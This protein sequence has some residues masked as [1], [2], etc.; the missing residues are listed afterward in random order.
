MIG[1]S[2]GVDSSVAA[3]LLLEQ[4]FQV[5]GLFMKNWEEDDGSEYCTAKQDLEDASSVADKLGIRLHTCNFASEYW[6]KVFEYF[7]K[8][9]QLLRTP[10]PDILCNREIKFKAFM[11]YA[12]QLGAQKI[13]TGHY[14]RLLLAPTG[15]TQLLKGVDSNKD[16]AY[17]LHALNQKQLSQSLFP[18]GCY[19]K[20]QVRDLA[21][22]LGFINHAK[23]DSTGICFI[24][25]RRFREFLQRYLPNQ[26]GPI[27]TVS[28]QVIGQHSG[29]MYYTLGQRQG[30]AIGG[31]K[32]YTESP[33]YVAA[34]NIHDNALIVVQGE[35]HPTLLANGLMASL[36]HWLESCS[37]P[38]HCH[39]KIRHRQN[40][41]ACYVSHADHGQLMVK[42]TQSQRGINP[43]QFIVFYLEDVCLG[44][45]TIENVIT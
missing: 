40:D 4:G 15:H 18:L 24:G 21:K 30:L 36:P 3:W 35:D 22:H 12:L 8:E 2:G 1:L 29:L 28:N 10:N 13:A 43:G 25:E 33:W 5:E 39:A 26:P 38:L 9:Y 44:G 41:Q 42:F 11:N 37:L 32:N 16:Q 6:D 7:L 14:A 17:F 23:K 45:A 27:V 20:K 19:Y 31:V 34:K